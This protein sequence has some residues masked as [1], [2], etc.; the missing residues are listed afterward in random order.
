MSPRTWL[1]VTLATILCATPIVS[2]RRKLRQQ[3]EL[4]QS[5]KRA[6]VGTAVGVSCTTKKVAMLGST[7]HQCSDLGDVECDEYYGAYTSSTGKPYF[8]VCKLRIHKGKSGSTSKCKKGKTPCTLTPK[9][10]MTMIQAEATRITADIPAS[11]TPATK[12]EFLEYMLNE[13]DGFLRGVEFS[14]QFEYTVK[15]QQT[16]ILAGKRDVWGP[17]CGYFTMGLKEL[18][19][20]ASGKKMLHRLQHLNLKRGQEDAGDQGGAQLKEANRGLNAPNRDALVARVKAPVTTAPDYIRIGIGGHSFMLER[21]PGGGVGQDGSY[22]GTCA[23]YQVWMNTHGLAYG[24]F[25]EKK[26]Q[27]QPITGAITCSKAAAVLNTALEGDVPEWDPTSHTK[28]LPKQRAAREAA[29]RFFAG[30]PNGVGQGDTQDRFSL[31]KK[32]NPANEAKMKETLLEWE[33]FSAEE[34]DE[35]GRAIQ[36]HFP[37]ALHQKVAPNKLFWTSLTEDDLAATIFDFVSRE[38]VMRDLRKG[39]VR[40]CGANGAGSEN[41]NMELPGKPSCETPH[42]QKLEF[43]WRVCPP[44]SVSGG[45]CVY[46][47]SWNNEL[48]LTKTGPDGAK[49][50]WPAYACASGMDG[51]KYISEQHEVHYPY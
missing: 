4:Q 51:V 41:K 48:R 44:T 43:G 28:L 34:A 20:E 19:E 27:L 11:R 3:L 30:D 39:R 38:D 47:C 31:D 14:D 45:E 8:R 37:D 10:L 18:F 49:G 9:T 26:G 35:A 50:E 7:R 5:A 42:K 12:I 16:S 25:T 17:S 23:V 1:C 2:G 33:A 40:F 29:Q 32:R 13:P 21:R 36:S 24:I 46:F 22:L 15:S 6:T